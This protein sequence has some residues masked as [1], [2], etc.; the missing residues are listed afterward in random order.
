MQNPQQFVSTHSQR[1][2]PVFEDF[3]S[4]PRE[5][6]RQQQQQQPQNAHGDSL[7]TKANLLLTRSISDSEREQKDVTPVPSRLPAVSSFPTVA[8]TP[9]AIHPEL[10]P[11]GTCF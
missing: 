5:H 9:C 3:S 4:S 7:G 6:Q 1:S 8:T 2:P 10:L 11:H